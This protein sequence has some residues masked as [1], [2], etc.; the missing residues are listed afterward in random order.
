MSELSKLPEAGQ[1]SRIAIIGNDLHAWCAA[2]LFAKKLQRS[3]I[4]L[5]VI[6]DGKPST[7]ITS[8]HPQTL[9][10]FDQLAVQ[11]ADLVCFLGASYTLGNVC[12]N[13]AVSQPHFF[14]YDSNT[15]LID[16]IAF[17][18]YLTA[19][20]AKRSDVGFEAFSI[21]AIAA[22]NL[23]FAHP[24]KDGPLSQLSYG[25]QFDQAALQYFFQ[26]YAGD[27]GVQIIAA[28]IDQVI[29]SDVD[30]TITALILSDQRQFSADFYFDASGV[31]LNAV[32]AISAKQAT[33][34]YSSLFRSNTKIV[35]AGRS[36]ATTPPNNTIERLEDNGWVHSRYLSGIVQQEIFFDRAIGLPEIL[37]SQKDDPTA[38]L[39]QSKPVDYFARQRHWHGNVVCIGQCAGYVGEFIFDRLYFTEHAITDWLSLFPRQRNEPMLAEQFNRIIFEQYHRVLDAHALL[40]YAALKTASGFWQD[41]EPV[42]RYPDSVL[43]RIEL[44]RQ[45]GQVAFYEADAMSNAQ[46]IAAMT[47]M[48][49]WPK[50]T[51]NMMIDISHADLEKRLSLIAEKIKDVVASMPKHDDLLSAIKNTRSRNASA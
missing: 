27:H 28:S 21:N 8:L 4:E 20:H 2:A 24:S 18:H 15:P 42:G 1:I 45:T 17:H 41:G 43:H 5:T 38:I 3:G 46:W 37:A 32:D 25:M 31:M 12:I 30:Q 16:R 51:D 50:R 23:R 35:R 44:F 13:W 9:R 33:I 47:A 22:S 19:L 26:S 11:E 6:A 34:G 29:H 36:T 10:V 48:N 49:I 14:G 7:E 40:I 39:S